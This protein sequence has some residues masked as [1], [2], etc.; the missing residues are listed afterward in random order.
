MKGALKRL[1]PAMVVAMIA[2]LVALGGTAGAA[3]VLITGAQIKNGTIGLADLSP[4]AKSSLRG[5]SGPTGPQGSA[6]P[7]GNAGPQG[8]Q[9]S[10]GERGPQGSPGSKGEQGAPGPASLDALDGKPCEFGV[11]SVRYQREWRAT[12]NHTTRSEVEGSG[13]RPVEISCISADR[14]EENDVREAAADIS[15]YW[16]VDSGMSDVAYATLVPAGDDDWYKVLNADLDQPSYYPDEAIRVEAGSSPIFIDVYRDGAVVATAVKAYK[17]TADD[18]AT[19]H[20][21]EIRVHGAV[22]APYYLTLT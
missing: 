13:N 6:G 9:G 19:P 8:A 10:Q 12:Y 16:K 3:T 20:D 14:F 22:A 21:W 18:L 17:L 7:Q 11:M 15:A 5:Q 1:T 2:L 4:A